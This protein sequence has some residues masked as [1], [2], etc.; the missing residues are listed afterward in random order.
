MSVEYGGILYYLCN[1]KRLNFEKT[2]FEELLHFSNNALNR[3]Q[4]KVTNFKLISNIDSLAAYYQKQIDD[5]KKF[6]LKS[7]D[8]KSL[9]EDILNVLNGI[10]ELGELEAGWDDEESKPINHGSIQMGLSI[11]S[12]I[13][14]KYNKV[15]SFIAPT[16]YSGVL[17]EYS[18]INDRIDIRI[19]DRGESEVII[20][21]IRNKELVNQRVHFSYDFLNNLWNKDQKK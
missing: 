13:F 4:G 8:S 9:E 6:V 3:Y 18:V 1:E 16:V 11:A 21:Y 20:N 17:I 7:G 5:I 10:Y 14:M 12:N 2:I 19:G 15:P